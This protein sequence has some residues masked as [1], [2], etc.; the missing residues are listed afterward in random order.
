[1]HD[2]VKADGEV[3]LSRVLE[4]ASHRA[5]GSENGGLLPVAVAMAVFQCTVERRLAK[6][7][8][9]RVTVPDPDRRVTVPLFAGRRYRGHE[10]RLVH[11]GAVHASEVSP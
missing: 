8:R 1:L 6:R 7:H 10:I 4:A 2:A 11:L 5:A 9:I 3:L